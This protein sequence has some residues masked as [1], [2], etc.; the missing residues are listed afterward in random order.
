MAVAFSVAGSPATGALAETAPAAGNQ[1][2]SATPAVAPAQW[3]KVCDPKDAK[4][5]QI[6]EDYG[7]VGQ[8]TALGSIAIQTSPDPKKF[9]VAIQVPLGF[10]VDQGVPLVVDGA[11]KANAPFITCVPSQQ[12]QSYF[13]VAQTSVDDGFVNAL[14]KGKV[15]RLSLT[16]IDKTSATLDFPLDTFAQAFDG[17]DQAALAR[18]RDNAAKILAEKAKQRAKQ[19]EGQ[20]K[21]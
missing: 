21:K 9:A 3:V 16:T 4:I 20:Q 17:P 14:K 7:L 11:K 2:Q 8:N 10:L 15:L 13:C 12:T 1:N 6:S 19:L 18:E 5:C